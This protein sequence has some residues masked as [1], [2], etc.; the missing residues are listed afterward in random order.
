M[1]QEAE[2]GEARATGQVGGRRWNEGR[3]EEDMEDMR[4]GIDNGGRG[5]EGDSGEATTRKI[6]LRRDQEQDE[7]EEG[8][9]TRITDGNN[10]KTLVGKKGGAQTYTG[11]EKTTENRSEGTCET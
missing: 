8:T 2:V 3:W 6:N 5:H 10:M 9:G 11:H 1:K 4:T 7:D